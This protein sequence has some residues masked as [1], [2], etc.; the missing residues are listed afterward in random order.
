MTKVID[1]YLLRYFLTSFLVV[2]AA[3]SLLIVAI[4]MVEELRDFIDNHIPLS[5]VVTYYIYLSGGYGNRSCRSLY[6]W[7][8]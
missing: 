5:Q 6:C 4:N 1:R 7:R 3:F 2:I 8:R